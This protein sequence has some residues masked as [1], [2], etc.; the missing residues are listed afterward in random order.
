MGVRQLHTETETSVTPSRIIYIYYA[1]PNT[2]AVKRKVGTQGNDMFRESGE[3]N[4]S[5]LHRGTPTCLVCTDKVAVHKEHNL[6]RHYTTRHAE[7][8]AKYQG[9]E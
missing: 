2:S 7:E 1:A 9:D 8:Y 6:K 4:I 3:C 5:L